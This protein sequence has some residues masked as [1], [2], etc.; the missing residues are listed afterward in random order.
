MAGWTRFVTVTG[1]GEEGGGGEEGGAGKHKGKQKG[2]HGKGKEEK[3]KEKGEKAG[4]VLVFGA[5]KERE[6][7]KG[8]EKKERGKETGEKRRTKKAPFELLLCDM[9][10]TLLNSASKIA[11]STAEALR[12]AH[13]RG[14]RV[15]I[16]TGK[17]RPAAMSALG[18]AGLVGA[19]GIFSDKSPGVFLQGLRVY[20]KGGQ[21]VHNALLPSEVTQEGFEFALKHGK[22]LIGFCGDR[23][24]TLVDHPLVEALHTIYY[25]PRAEVMPSV[26]HIINET[27]I[28]KL[29]FYDTPHGID[30][31]IRPF[32][33]AATAGRATVTQA[34]PDMLEILPPG[35]SKGAGV[36]VLLDHLKLSAEQVM[37][38]GDGE[39]DLEM[40]EMVG[41]GVAM[42]NGS[43]KTKAVAKATVASNDED[44]NVQESANGSSAASTP[45][46]HKE[47]EALAYS[48]GQSL[49]SVLND[50]RLGKAGI[51][52]TENAWTWITAQRPLE[53]VLEGPPPLPPEIQDFPMSEFQPYLQRMR[54]PY[55]RFVDVQEHSTWELATGEAPGADVDSEG[56]EER[57]GK[58][59]LASRSEGQG[60]AAC[61]REIPPVYFD[62]HFALERKEIFD[63]VCPSP[64]IP[65][66][67]LLQEK[68]SH[69]LDLVEVHLVKEISS[70]S[71]S[72]FEALEKLEDLNRGI[73]ETCDRIRLLRGTVGMLDE[74]LLEGSRKLQSTKVRRE[75]LLQLHQKLKLVA[76]VHQAMATLKLLVSSGDCAGALDVMDDLRRLM[77]GQ[78][79]AGLHCFRPLNDLLL[80]SSDAVN[81]LLTADFVREA[82][83]DDADVAPSAIVTSFNLQKS[84]PPAA[85]LL[86]IVNLERE[87]MEEREARLREHLLPLVI[88]LL[89][90]SR[91]PAVLRAY[92]DAVNVDIKAAVKTVVGEL[93]PLLFLQHAA[94]AAAGGAPG[95]AGGEGGDAAADALN[96]FFQPTNMYLFNQP[97]LSSHSPSLTHPSF[98]SPLPATSPSTPNPAPSL[99]LKL[100]ALAPPAFVHLLLAVFSAVQT[101]LVRAAAVRNVVSG[102]A[103]AGVAA[104]AAAAAAEPAVGYEAAAVAAAFASGAELVVAAEAAESKLL[105]RKG[106]GKGLGGGGAAGGVG[107]A[108]GS[109]EAAGG[110]VSSVTALATSKQL[111]A[112]VLRENAE[113][114]SDA[115][116]VAHGRWAKLLGV[117]AQV[118]PKLS[119][120]DFVDMYAVTS[121]FIAST[122]RVGGRLG[123]SIRGALQSQAKAFVETHHSREMALILSLLNKE[124]WTAVDATPHTQALVD[125]F[126]T[127][128]DPSAEAAAAAAADAAAAVA[129]SDAAAAAT[130]VAADAAT[131]AAA[132]AAATA[133]AAANEAAAA[134]A[135]DAAATA[136]AVN[137]AAASDAAAAGVDGYR[138]ADEAARDTAAANGPMTGGGL[139]QAGDGLREDGA[140]ES[141]QLE[142]AAEGDM[143][144]GQGQ[145]NARRRDGSVATE[146]GRREGC[147]GGTEVGGDGVGVMGQGGATG[148]GEAETVGA[149][150]VEKGG[151]LRREGGEGEAEGLQRR[152]T[153]PGAAASAAATAAGEAPPVAAVAPAPPTEAAAPAAASSA[154]AAPAAAS[155]AP[156][157]PAAAAAA[158]PASP[159]TGSAEGPK[160]QKRAAVKT[161]VCRGVKYHVTGS[162]CTLLSVTREYVAVAEALPSLAGEVVQRLADVLK[163]F[164]SRTC[165]LVLGAGAMQVSGLK[166]ITA[167][168]LALSSQCISLVY[169]LIP[170]LRRILSAFIPDARRGLV[171]THLDR[172]AQDYRVHRDEI[173]SKLVA[174]MRERL[175]VHLRSLPAVADT[176]CRLDD[177]PAEQQPSNFAR[178]LTKEVG[179]LHRI[180]SPLLLEADLRSIFSRVVALFHVQL[181]DSFAKI[182]TPTPQAK[183]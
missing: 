139:A 119:L 176:Y 5:E 160:A 118:H 109:G 70:R 182:D 60:L 68:L 64:S 30:G 23:C 106:V 15:A 16:A 112:D 14:V 140:Q 152:E 90:T 156:A 150:G 69:Y 132:A 133:A 92:R 56:R 41:W 51:Y 8:K 114:V 179:V 67:M 37:A 18:A 12:A 127:F 177:S 180:L 102:I 17:A 111:R 21:V 74:D 48:S 7:K 78:E 82:V 53:P 22:A 125:F 71:D 25:E 164:N 126:C 55:G 167:K 174:I 101:R 40:I 158:S 34:V 113:A 136:A 129:A 138:A 1:E 172:V 4:K 147:E 9:D 28:Q 123:Y 130:A 149:E 144:E 11:P 38:I 155:P 81:S 39:N 96:A 97:S 94:A 95:G 107:G 20:G 115:C 31:F 29:L 73:V 65:A 83:H 128:L 154:A 148:R 171:I 170:D 137:M 141:V 120:S 46:S 151:E 59:I 173:H 49:A 42:A 85:T 45:R 116:E 84:V 98:P 33:S 124:T 13:A 3:G 121:D 169:A 35:Q 162:A 36:R 161:V 66:N 103:T 80:S 168:H 166:T 63:T 175:L 135:A 43:E 86:S 50:P 62:E 88:S 134:A 19:A 104:G 52:G 110:D 76:F 87:G 131:A 143:S 105:G 178:A 10:G 142:Q 61:L 93:L 27:P 122:E 159:A 24:V 145:A 117:R 100:R 181:A 146:G 26:H 108:A 79:L 77:E 99:A 6:H 153:V 163:L 165:Q 89:R 58:G 72:F 157:S 91:L 44:G 32:W 47:M 57:K 75:N 54:E 183:R 2:K